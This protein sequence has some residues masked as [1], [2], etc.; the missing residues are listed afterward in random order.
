MSKKVVV[1]NRHKAH[2]E[3]TGMPE[4]VQVKQEE[5]AKVIFRFESEEDLQEFA[6][7]IGQTLT[8]KTKSAWFPAKSHWRDTK[9]V[10]VDGDVE[11]RDGDTGEASLSDFL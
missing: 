2:E 9:Q 8:K 1:D 5:Y 7:L 3:W 11:E 6:Q 4:F 10:Y